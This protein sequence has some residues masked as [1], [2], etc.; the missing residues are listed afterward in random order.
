MMPKAGQSGNR[1]LAPD[2]HSRVLSY[3][4]NARRNESIEIAS[5]SRMAPVEEK[6]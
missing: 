6:L 3:F 1:S 2:N 5:A 4:Q